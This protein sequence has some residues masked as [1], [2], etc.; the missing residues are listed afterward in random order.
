[1][2]TPM[3]PYSVLGVAPSAPPGEVKA[4]YRARSRLL[5]PD[6]HRDAQG[7]SPQAAHE[8]FS[9]LCQAYEMALGNLDRTRQAIG[10]VEQTVATK[11]VAVKTRPPA[12]VVPVA[13]PA[14]ASPVT[15]LDGFDWRG[16]LLLMGVA[17]L[18]LLFVADWLPALFAYSAG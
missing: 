12:P 2:M 9:Q 14:G 3:D 11:T 15:S 7:Q 5:H 16:A 8:A 6:V 17:L 13:A 4:A 1:M 18:A 10:T